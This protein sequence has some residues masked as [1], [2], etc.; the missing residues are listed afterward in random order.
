MSNVTLNVH[1]VFAESTTKT[2]QFGPF[3]MDSDA[4]KNF[5]DRL[6]NLMRLMKFQEKNLQ[7]W[8]NFC[9]QKMARN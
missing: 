5:K 4:V 3:D 8:K 9:V 7:I 1:F 2:F 6:K